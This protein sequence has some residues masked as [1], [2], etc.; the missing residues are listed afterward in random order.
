MRAESPP[1]RN[2]YSVCLLAA[3]AAVGSGP[4]ASPAP[5]GAGP[6][7][8]LSPAQLAGQ[9]VIYSYR[10]LTPPRTLIAKIRA[11]EVAGVIF[12]SQNIASHAQI[13]SV[14]HELQAAN[15]QSPVHEPLLMLTDQEGGLVRR[16]SG[17]PQLSEKQIGASPHATALAA[18]EG[19]A[20]GKNLASVGINVDLAPVLDVYRQAGDFIDQYQRSYGMNPHEVAVLGGAFISSLQQ[21]GVAATGKH[22]PGLGAAEAGQDTDERRVTLRIPLR[23]LRAIDEEPYRAA[24]SA[25]VRLVMTSWAVYPALDPGRPAGLSRSV[26]EGELRDRLGFR[27]VTITDALDAGALRT[28]GTTAHRALLA[29]GAGADLLLCASAEAQPAEAVSVVTALARTLST[30]SLARASAEQAVQRIIALRASL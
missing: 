9:R 10:G 11:G 22:F 1:W 26:I 13:R 28:F 19:R 21:T 3:I 4:P 24:I 29:A 20:A 18:R 2:V 5:T 15:E 8:S 25:G 30:G 12:F 16:L 14:I 17:A 6:L 27:G 23:E 7:A